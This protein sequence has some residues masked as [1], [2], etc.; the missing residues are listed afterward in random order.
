MLNPSEK[1]YCL[2]LQALKEKQYRQ[3]AGHF[4]RAATFFVDNK[5][6]NLLRET[7][8]LLVALKD[9]LAATDQISDE[10]LIV[11]EVFSNG[12]ET[13]VHGQ[14]DQEVARGGLSDL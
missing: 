8:R 11:Q 4:D 5:E 3:A 2:A 6:F 7:T 9:E 12:Q 10:T 14:D 13:D 1:A